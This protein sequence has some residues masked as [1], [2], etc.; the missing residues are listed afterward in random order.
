MTVKPCTHTN[1]ENGAYEQS[2][3]EKS[4]RVALD[5]I[6]SLLRMDLDLDLEKSNQIIE[7]KERIE[8]LRAR[9]NVLGCPFNKFKGKISSLENG[10]F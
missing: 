9:I 10:H 6:F 1:S 4:S 5:L 7:K 2:S 3:M 8:G